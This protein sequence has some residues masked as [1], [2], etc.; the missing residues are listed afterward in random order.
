MDTW[1]AGQCADPVTA[2]CTDKRRDALKGMGKGPAYAYGFFRKVFEAQAAFQQGL[3]CLRTVPEHGPAGE[4]LLVAAIGC[5]QAHTCQQSCDHAVLFFRSIQGNV[6][7]VHDFSQRSVHSG[8]GAAQQSIPGKC[9][10]SRSYSIWPQ[11][12]IQQIGAPGGAKI[13]L[14]RF[15]GMG[16]AAQVI[17]LELLPDT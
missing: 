13:R 12:V 6:Y 16:M 7:I 1:K 15:F 3:Q 14:D 4:K 9:C 5:R 2:S 10:Q 8:E 11:K 17:F